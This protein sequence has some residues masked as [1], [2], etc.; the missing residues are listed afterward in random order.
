MC[1]VQ[2]AAATSKARHDLNRASF[3]PSSI[4]KINKALLAGCIFANA[5]NQCDTPGI[6]GGP[7]G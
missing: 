5:P 3:F 7:T 6:G 2:W 4:K 1:L